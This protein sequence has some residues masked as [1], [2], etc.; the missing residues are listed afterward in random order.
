MPVKL[1]E[2]CGGPVRSETGVCRKNQE[3]KREFWRRNQ[4]AK[5]GGLLPTQPCAVCSRPTWGKYGVCNQ[6]EACRREHGRLSAQALLLTQGRRCRDFGRCGSTANLRS[7]YCTGCA[8]EANKR[9]KKAR[10]SALVQILGERQEWTCPWCDVELPEDLADVE[11]DHII[12]KA[13]GLVIEEDWNLQLLHGQCNVK[14]F[15]R[16][17]AQAIELAAEHGLQLCSP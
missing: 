16:I 6:T 13:S 15:S 10:R 17:T 1:C 4:A 9:H 7:H 2:V 8:S 11:V 5:R 14:K 3:C 12:P